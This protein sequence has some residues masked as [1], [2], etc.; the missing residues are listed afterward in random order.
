M[1]N[2]YP[3]DISNIELRLRKLDKDIQASRNQAMQQVS[4]AVKGASSS[5]TQALAQHVASN[6]PHP[7][8]LLETA[9]Q[10]TYQTLQTA[11]F[12]LVK[13]SLAQGETLTIAQDQ[14][15]LTYRTFTVAGELT[16]TGELV[17]L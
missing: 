6:D 8:Y 15:L 5:N 16:V 17:L 1:A 9:A 10:V 13:T 2:I 11:R 4:V 14:Q 12:P 7:S 3:Q